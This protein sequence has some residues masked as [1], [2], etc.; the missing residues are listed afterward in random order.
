[1]D[2]RFWAI[3]GVVIL[4]FVGIIW[5]NN[6]KAGAPDNNSQATNHVEGSNAKNVTLVEYGDYQCPVCYV[7]YPV[8][9]QAVEKYKGDIKFQFRNFPITSAHPN[10]LA[11]ARAAEAAA[12]QNKFWEMHDLLYQNQ[13]PNGKAG[14]VAS[15]TPQSFFETFA[16]Q[17][18]LNA[19]QFKKDYASEKVNDLI[20]ADI[21]EANKVKVSG[22][23]SFFLNGE[24]LP[25]EKLVDDKTRQPSVDKLSQA[26]DAAIAKAAKE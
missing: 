16:K 21:R 25:L 22:T 13:D 15:G 11:G 6:K 1:M 3:I 24:A 9:K 7:Y 12:L 5:A 17:L 23:P 2:K 8:V 10:A 18:N 20:N 26:I 14:W 19:E 4:I